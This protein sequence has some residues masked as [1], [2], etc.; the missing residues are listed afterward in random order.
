[1]DRQTI[2]SEATLSGEKRQTTTRLFLTRYTP[3]PHVS[4]A[5]TT[6]ATAATYSCLVFRLLLPAHLNSSPCAHCGLPRT[7]RHTQSVA[8]SRRVRVV[9]KSRSHRLSA[10]LDRSLVRG[11][12][13][14][15]A[16]EWVL[17]LS[18]VFGGCCS[19]VSATLTF[20]LITLAWRL[21]DWISNVWA[22]EA[23]LKDHPKSGQCQV[24]I[25]Q[26]VSTLAELSHRRL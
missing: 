5:S 11:F 23:V 8:A 24:Q 15:A 2:Q 19:W 21:A 4:A 12:L 6:T 3:P 1:M 20:I 17:I 9:F 18:F 22:L 14:S 25:V 26:L 16:G 7:A 10:M 13:E